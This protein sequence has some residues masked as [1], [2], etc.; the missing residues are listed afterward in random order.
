MNR[1]RAI[2][3][4][5]LIVLVAASV[6]V[7]MSD[8]N[9][10]LTVEQTD[11]A[12]EDTAAID[13]IVL[14]DQDGA[15]IQLERFGEDRW[16]SWV[17]N[18][19]DGWMLNGERK[20]RQDA[21][22]LL[23]RTFRRIKVKSAVPNSS[24]NAINAQI[25]ATHIKVDIY[26]GGDEPVKTWYIGGPTQD[27]YGT[28]M[29]LST[30][31]HGMSAVPHIMHLPGFYGFL[32]AR[33][34]MDEMDWRWTGV[35]NYHP[36]E[37]AEISMDFGH[38]PAESFRIRYTDDEQLFLLNN[39]D[40]E[41]ANFDTIAVKNYILQYKKVHFETF[42]KKL[43]DAQKDS[44]LNSVPLYTIAV[45]NKKGD[46]NE[47]KIFEKAALPGTTNAAGDTLDIDPERKVAYYD[48][49]WIIV[50]NFVFDKLFVPLSA[51]AGGRTLVPPGPAMDAIEPDSLALPE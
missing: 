10:T 17:L 33:F 11:F 20:A 3:A 4:V 35:F 46:R 5:L 15:T 7:T 34:F 6:W 25:G 36:S 42:D 18:E 39:G 21:V 29:V 24:T 8:S 45:T 38:F 37:I 1:K 13:K 31:E 19:Y 27:H 44:I 16:Y 43:T 32:T 28:Y 22:D 23:M 40:F 51:L 48:G 50:Q 2:T 12:I 47:I 9:S 30:P 26:Q 49:E 14:S 41:F